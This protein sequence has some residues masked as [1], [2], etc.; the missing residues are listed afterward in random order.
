MTGLIQSV[1]SDLRFEEGH[2]TS[3]LNPDPA[4]TRAHSGRMY[5]PEGQNRIVAGVGANGRP[6]VFPCDSPNTRREVSRYR[7]VVEVALHDRLEPSPGWGHGIVHAL[8][9]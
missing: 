4:R 8:A 1:W 6:T 3:S 5:L 7:V 9:G 2:S